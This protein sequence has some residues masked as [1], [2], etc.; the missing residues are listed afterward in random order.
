MLASSLRHDF[1]PERYR[2][3]S[4]SDTPVQVLNAVGRF[5]ATIHA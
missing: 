1:V 3:R 4:V 5:S 2:Q